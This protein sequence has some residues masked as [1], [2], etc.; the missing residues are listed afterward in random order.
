MLLQ[1]NSTIIPVT[2]QIKFTG[3]NSGVRNSVQPSAFEWVAGEACLD[4]N[5]TASWS[6][7]ESREDRLQTVRDLAEWGE[8][9]GLSGIAA[10]GDPGRALEDAKSLRETLHRIFSPLSRWH[11]PVADDLAE[12][13]RY[14]ARALSRAR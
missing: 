12:F 14:L 3:Y 6:R 10:K 5:N 7:G 1:V 4:F 11:A 13:N 2:C 8:R 9:A